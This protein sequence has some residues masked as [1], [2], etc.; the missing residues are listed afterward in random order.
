LKLPAAARLR[1]LL[2]IDRTLLG[3]FVRTASPV[4]LGEIL[5]SLG[6]TVYTAIYARIGT[7]S[8]AGVSIASTLEGVALVPFLG[9]GNACAIMLGN[10]IGAGMVGDAMDYARRFLVLAI[11][12]ALVMGLVIFV[13]RSALLALY[14]ISPE[15]QLAARSVLAVMSVALWL[16]AGNIMM[17][18]GIMRSGGDTRFALLA[19]TV[20]MW[21]LGVPTALLGA[22]VLSLPVYGVVLLVLMMDEGT[23]FFISLRRV[24]SALWIHNVVQA[25]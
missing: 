14:R 8:V 19:D 13:S 15:A 22:F 11:S 24:R 3:R 21:L 4:I 6:I 1:E 10:R 9:M 12:G 18:I 5:W 16:K 17:V 20:P 25:I 23:K 7:D 2:D